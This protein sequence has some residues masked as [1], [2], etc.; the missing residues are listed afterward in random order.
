[1][2]LDDLALDE[3]EAKGRRPEETKAAHQA[4]PRRTGRAPQSIAAVAIR[5]AV[6]DTTALLE[7]TQQADSGDTLTL[8][9]WRA[10]KR[11]RRAGDAN[12]T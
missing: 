5:D 8:E 12:S 6:R 4:V 3:E 10:F 1:M 11:A 9:E 7:A 2:N